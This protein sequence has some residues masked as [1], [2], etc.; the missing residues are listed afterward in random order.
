MNINYW[1]SNGLIRGYLNKKDVFVPVLSLHNTLSG[2]KEAFQP[3]DPGHIR[4]YACGPTVY[5]YAHI[6]N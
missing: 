5:D 2:Q 1:C 6:G 4:V 3:I